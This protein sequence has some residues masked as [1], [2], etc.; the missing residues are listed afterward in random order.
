[1]IEWNVSPAMNDWELLQDYAVRGSETAF[2]ALVSK[3]L[4]LVYSAALRQVNDPHRAE[5][6]SQAVFI[7]LAR[8]AST[9]GRGVILA[10]WLFRTTRFVAARA[11]RSERRRQRREQEAFA[12][13]QHTTPDQTWTRLR[14]ILD[15]ALAQL[16]EA[17]R[18]A[19]LLRF[20]E[21]LNH[22][23]VGAALGVS[24]EAA[25]KRVNRAMER[26]RQFFARRG[27][28]LSATGMASAL[29]V[30]AVLAT[31]PGLLT[32]VATAAVAGGA[33]ATG[34]LPI[35]ARETLSAWRWARLRLAISVGAIVTVGLLLLDGVVPQERSLARNEAPDSSAIPTTRRVARIDVTPGETVSMPPETGRHLGLRVVDAETNQ[36]LA[37]VG[38]H[39][40][41]WREG[42]VEGRD[43]LR[44]DQQGLC[45]VPLPESG[46]DRLD[47]GVLIDGYVQK[48]VSWYAFQ[49]DPAPSEYL[50]RLERGAR[51]GGWVT[52]E[53]GSPIAGAEI[54]IGFPG[55]GDHANFERQRERV[56]F[57]DDLTVAK[58]AWDGSWMCSIVPTNE[59]CFSIKVRHPDFD[60]ATYFSDADPL[61]YVNAQRFRLQELQDRQA[62][63]VLGKGVSLTGWVVDGRQNP[64]AGATV[65]LD[66][67]AG[68][69]RG[70]AKTDAN[71]SFAFE[72]VGTGDWPLRVSAGGFAPADIRVSVGPE[73]SPVRIELAREATLRLRV[74]DQ[75]GT[76]VPQA[77]V[78][79]QTGGSIPVGS[80][81]AEGR[82]EFLSA[83]GQAK[84][85]HVFKSGFFNS[86]DNLLQAD[87]EEQTIVLSRA[88]EVTGYVVDAQSRQP[89]A[90][91]KA[92]PGLGY[93]GP[94]S[95]M[96]GDLRL[97]ERGRYTLSFVEPAGFFSVR[98]E[99]DG[100]EPAWQTVT[101][102]TCDFE[103]TKAASSP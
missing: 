73:A 21:D 14:P 99:A 88:L 49:G 13:Q 59:S 53:S 62:V 37:G 16:G 42:R 90:A 69:P 93:G 76:G 78:F 30:N 47:V 83:A 85:V 39:A 2:R 57:I 64:I 5:E 41:F 79:L 82:L 81:D 11:Q 43:D 77:R 9:F 100:Y 17:D 25:K 19:V 74:L 12:M 98:I 94:S 22:R 31:P 29:G 46:L 48:F 97:G 1:M 38:V 96:R 91:F 32:N 70:S 40:R 67:S 50:M 55:I 24:E 34:A 3:H 45:E 7:L 33:A 75:R 58:T 54:S 63:L 102:P 36:G 56:G 103:L 60:M 51:I 26:L 10:G 35:L 86:R 65:E 4:P 8:K 72:H 44:T 92:I 95:W 84:R 28:A 52:D 18:N 6:V 61:D 27:F 87:G 68:A 89:I 101:G 20:F 80:S 71:G 15:E 23:Q 66:A